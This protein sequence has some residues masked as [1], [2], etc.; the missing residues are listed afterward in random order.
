MTYQEIKSFINTYI[1]QNG[2][3]A[4]T[5]SRLNTALNA[6]A[7]YYGFDSVVVTTL[8][9]G[10]DA[11]VNVQGRTLE[12]GIPKGADGSDGRDGL[13]AVNPFK[14]WFDSL[15]DLKASY[16]ASIGDSAYVKDASPAT[17]WSIYIYDSTASSDNY[18]ADSG[19]DADTSHVQTFA[20]GEE[21][22][23]VTID[24]SHLVNPVNTTN[25]SQPVLARAEDVMQLLDK[26]VN[27]AD[28]VEYASI[29]KNLFDKQNFQT[30]KYILY[31]NSGWVNDTNAVISQKLYL[32]DKQEYTVSNIIIGGTGD[33]KQ[34]CIVV[35]DSN[36]DVLDVVKVD[37]V[38]TESSTASGYYKDQG[39]ATFIWNKIEGEAYCRIEINYNVRNQSKYRYAQLELGGEATS[40][41]EYGAVKSYD[42]AKNSEFNNAMIDIDKRVDDILDDIKDLNT[43]QDGLR[44][45]EDIGVMEGDAQGTSKYY[46]GSVGGTIKTRSASSSFGVVRYNVEGGAQYYFSN[47]FG[48]GIYSSS[49]PIYGLIFTNENN[50]IIDKQFLSK[51]GSVDSWEDA[52]VVAPNDAVY[53]YVNYYTPNISNTDFLKEPIYGYI[54]VDKLKE[55]VDEL[56]EA[57]NPSDK[58]MKVVIGENYFRV[59]SKFSDSEDIIIRFAERILSGGSRMS[60]SLTL[61]SYYVGANTL[62]DGEL[63]TSQYKIGDPDDT[64]SAIAFTGFGPMTGQHGWSIARCSKTGTSIDNS[65]LNSVWHDKDN[66]NRTFVLGYIS[67]SYLYFFPVITDNNGI[68]GTTTGAVYNN[69]P[70]GFVHDSGATHTDA[71]NNASSRYDLRVETSQWRFFADGHKVGIGTYYCDDFVFTESVVGHSP[72]GVSY[73]DWIIDNTDAKYDE[74]KNFVALSRS[75]IFKGASMTYNLSFN[76][77]YPFKLSYFYF[78][79]PML[80]IKYTDTDS[81]VYHAN[82]FVPKAKGICTP[83]VNDTGMETGKSYYKYRNSTDLYNVNDIPDRAIGFLKSDSNTYK[84]GMVG[85]LSLVDG[86]TVKQERNT[87]LA[88]IG[89]STDVSHFG[90][91][92]ASKNKWYTKVLLSSSFSNEV[93]PATFVKDVSGYVCWFDPNK[94]AGLQVYNYKASD[95][96][97]IYIHAQATADKKEINLPSYLEGLSVETIIEKTPGASLLTSQI[98]C[99]K[100]YVKFEQNNGTD[101]ST[102]D[103]YIVIKVK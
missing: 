41:A 13:D 89:Q 67:D 26:K 88:N 22:N 69:L 60:Q 17:T 14:G 98:I 56:M 4:I 39:K 90:N 65:D 15:A 71:I 61:N 101:Y 99:G 53:A 64:I 42:I 16:T 5:G 96:Y 75:Y 83:Y 12:L 48:S 23:Q 76:T 37:G 9:A 100:L 102:N 55:D 20:S 103:N 18:W 81:T 78:L 52:P 94:N 3:G 72:V 45:L 29:R 34:A 73:N 62:T 87:Y 25:S 1:V 49:Y 38:V 2:V 86:I 51:Q 10:S 66:S 27:V 95:S 36:D 91:A 8:P 79:H 32:Q 44:Y 11:T 85:G 35:F 74:S 7:D 77:L 58:L 59:R 47:R 31:K 93:V 70:S 43:I 82:L 6:L 19:I 92:S 54:K 30:G 40:Y 28:L 57:Y 50:I 46:Y 97:V 21:L 80:P 33:T 24:D 68:Y 63:M 84:L